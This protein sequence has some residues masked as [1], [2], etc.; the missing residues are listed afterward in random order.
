[1]EMLTEQ[2]KT[3]NTKTE[4]EYRRKHHIWCTSWLH[5]KGRG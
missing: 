2:N 3:S 5:S 4:N 1:M